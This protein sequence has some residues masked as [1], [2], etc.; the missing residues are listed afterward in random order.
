MRESTPGVVDVLPGPAHEYWLAETTWFSFAWPEGFDLCAPPAGEGP[1]P[2]RLTKPGGAEIFP[3]GPQSTTSLPTGG[4]WAAPGQELVT[5]YRVEDIDVCELAYDHEDSPWWQT[6]WAVP[7]GA[8]S[9]LVM[10][11]Q[12]PAADAHIVRSAIGEIID[13]MGPTQ[14]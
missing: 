10:T 5:Q 8:N 2:F 12:A 3:Q 13:T 7:V 9:S 1:T 4:N 14:T 6:H 11:G